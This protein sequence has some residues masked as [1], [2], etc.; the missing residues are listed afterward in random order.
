MS[1]SFI[2]LPAFNQDIS[3]W[4]MSNVTDMSGTFSSSSSFNQDL[5][6]W[7]VSNVTKMGGMFSFAS[8]FNQ[9]L[10]DW[11]VDKVIDW[12]K[13]SINATTWTAPKPNFTNC[14]E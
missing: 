14:L 2:D 5:S 12:N 9:D 10:S 1:D 11:V 8:S 4:D 13:F 6:A 3:P 7:E